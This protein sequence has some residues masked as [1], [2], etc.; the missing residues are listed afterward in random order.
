MS[1][2]SQGDGA[3][4]ISEEV[5]AQSFGAESTDNTTEVTPTVNVAQEIALLKE[6]NQQ[7]LH[8]LQQ[9]RQPSVEQPKVHAPQYT[10]AQ[11]AEM[12]KTDP[13]AVLDYLV[14]QRV[15]TKMAEATTQ[16]TTVQ[17]RTYWDEKA[18]RDFPQVQ[19]DK[20]FKDQFQEAYREL[21]SSG[22]YTTE[23]PKVFYRAA[24]RA[25]LKLASQSQQRKTV[26]AQG[27]MTG[28][29]P[30]SSSQAGGQGKLKVEQSTLRMCQQMG[31]KDVEGMQ[32]T[33]NERRARTTLRRG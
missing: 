11:L 29:A 13:D 20:A 1:I 10:K 31:I 32:K 23:H 6:Q 7:V 15:T 8:T 2:D 24:E 9:F 28:E 22:E 14:D 25:A 12:M 5:E 16:L 27:S 21:T 19:K 4:Q 3:A 33:L 30:R 17:Q 26:S 18:L